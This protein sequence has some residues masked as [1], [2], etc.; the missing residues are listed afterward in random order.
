[1][2]MR[3][4]LAK[5]TTGRCKGSQTKKST[6]GRIVPLCMKDWVVDPCPDRLSCFHA[7]EEIGCICVDLDWGND[8][9]A[10][11]VAGRA[12]HAQVQAL[13]SEDK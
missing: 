12:S 10:L 3:R 5:I 2:Q 11:L 8:V 13:L 9:S 1:M 7:D 6:G 4:T